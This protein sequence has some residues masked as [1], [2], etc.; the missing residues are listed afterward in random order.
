MTHKLYLAGPDIFFPDA[1]PRYNSMRA[2]CRR[3]GLAALTPADNEF[4][5]EL[6]GPEIAAFIKDANIQLIRAA[7]GVI[8]HIAPFRGPHMDV[9]TAWEIGYAEALGK[10]VF[11]WM[12]KPSLMIERIP[13]V[14]NGSDANGALVEDFGLVENLMIGSAEHG[15]MDSF[16][17]AAAKAKAVL[18]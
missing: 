8:A 1:T 9:G 5:V 18:G 14:S 13:P 12:D 10:P 2:I 11:L 6:S 3:H 7:D 16:E 15:V 17:A 4:P